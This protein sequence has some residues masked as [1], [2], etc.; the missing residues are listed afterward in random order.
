[1]GAIFLVYDQEFS[2]LDSEIYVEFVVIVVVA[3]E[4]N[5]Q[6]PA[7]QKRQ[8]KL[9]MQPSSSFRSSSCSISYVVQLYQLWRIFCVVCFIDLM[10]SSVL[11]PV[12]P[13]YRFICNQ[14]II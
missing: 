2:L 10:I 7:K 8:E 5:Q 1:M 3:Q 6:L 12:P 4:Q 11:P 14:L 13:C 9:S